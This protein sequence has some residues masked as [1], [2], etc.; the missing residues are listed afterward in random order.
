MVLLES[1]LERYDITSSDVARMKSTNNL[2]DTINYKRIAF[3]EKQ[4]PEN[5]R[6]V[7]Q[8]RKDHLLSQKFLD[9][10]HSEDIAAI[11]AF[12][13]SRNQVQAKQFSKSSDA[14][15]KRT[16]CLMDATGSM[17]A[18]LTKA[19]N[20]VH[21]MFERACAIL[22]EKGMAAA[23]ELQFVVYR[24]YDCKEERILQYSGWESDPN[25]LRQFMNTIDASG[26][27]WEPEAI[28]IGLW[29]ANR[30]AETVKI[31][32]VILIGDAPPNPRELVNKGRQE[33]LGESYWETT[34]FSNSTYVD[35]EVEK[36]K[37]KGI[38]VHAFYVKSSAKASFEKIAI[39]TTGHYEMLDIDSPEGAEKLTQIVTERIL[40][41][42]GGV[43]LVKLYR[44]KYVR[45]YLAL[46][47]KS[48]ALVFS[49]QANDV[50]EQSITEGLNLAANNTVSGATTATT[51]K[52]SL[53][54]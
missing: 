40:E 51:I 19:K 41:D 49:K 1:E 8:I 18:L 9:A 38:P 44:A 46:E 7:D 16:I 12:L 28:E 10:I 14:F 21:T 11:K 48:S 37:Q 39:T 4:F 27:T 50:R 43:E 20:T 45:G 22:K 54:C 34:K 31:N 17:H 30:V 36:L 47:K 52:P 25:N 5:I 3:F 26:G 32:Q 42:L 35:D 6:Q 53:L 24:N 13:K 15:L 2:Y 29:H 33:Y 23:F